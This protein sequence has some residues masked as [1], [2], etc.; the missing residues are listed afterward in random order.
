MTMTEWAK[1]KL[2]LHVKKKISIEKKENGITVVL[3]MKA[4]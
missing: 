3:V 1:T 4:L 2:L